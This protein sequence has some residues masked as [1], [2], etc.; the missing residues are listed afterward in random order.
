MKRRLLFLNFIVI[1]LLAGNCFGQIPTSGMIAGYSFTGNANDESTNAN[2]GTVYGAI[3]TTNR[4]GT[5]NAAYRFDGVDDYI[6]VPND[7]ALTPAD[8]FT[9]CAELKVEGFYSGNCQVSTIFQKGAGS[10]GY[11]LC[12]SDNGY[13]GESCSNYDPAHMTF[14]CI[15]AGVITSAPQYYP[16]FIANNQWYCLTGTFDGDSIR[17]YIDGVKMKTAYYPSAVGVN[18]GDLVF[19]HLVSTSFPYWFKGVI[20]DARIYNRVLTNTEIQGYCSYLAGIENHNSVSSHVTINTLGNGIY[21]LV[22]DRNYKKADV[23]IRTVLGQEVYSSRVN[24]SRKEMMNLSSFA[25]GIYLLNITTEEGQYT[26][27]LFKE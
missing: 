19:G 24:N 27:K 17:I 9:L 14:Q 20:D 4:L 25:K 5:P 8:S 1:T 23:T 15:K 13:D 18:T 16:S 10:G 7:P 26:T 2:N 3:L 21:E 11:G 22:L 12:F 6:Q